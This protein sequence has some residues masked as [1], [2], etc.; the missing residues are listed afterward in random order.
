MFAK[1]TI[2]DFV[3]WIDWHISKADKRARESV[4]DVRRKAS[5][6][7]RLN[8]GNTVLQSL[9]VVRSEFDAGVEAVLGELQRI[10]GKTELNREQLRRVTG[11]RLEDFATTAKTIAQIP[12]AVGVS[13]GV[14]R[15]VAEWGTALDDHLNFALHQFDVGIFEP[16]EPEM[17]PAARNY[18]NIGGNMTGSTIAQA[19][20]GA[21]QSV[22]FNLNVETINEA[23]ATFENAVA[24]ASLPLDAGF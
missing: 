7:G 22:E 10:I 18:I 9:E 2:D 23:L 6:A 16:A 15:H 4:E 1:P 11:E 12:E 19:S 14:N 13:A 8:S 17:P 21:K 3:G 20:P 24:S 5:A